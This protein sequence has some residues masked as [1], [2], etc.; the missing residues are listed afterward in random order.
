MAPYR[1]SR[2]PSSLRTRP[3]PA[4]RIFP[5]T[6]CGMVPLTREVAEGKLRALAAG[7]A[8]LRNELGGR[9]RR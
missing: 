2:S 8:L 4:A 9:E 3:A 1:R 5:C 7:A 6:N